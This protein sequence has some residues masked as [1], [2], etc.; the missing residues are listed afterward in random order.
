MNVRTAT[1]LDRDAIHHVH[2]SAFAD[3]ERA[4]VSKLAVNLLQEETSPNTI[5]LVAEL[6]GLVVGH[7]A[8]SPVRIENDENFRGVILAPLGVMPD[9]QNRRIG[10]TLLRSGMQLV[11]RMQA[12]VLFVYGDPKYYGK[13]GFSTDAAGCYVPPY[14]LK[15]PFGWQAIA[16]NKSKSR[17]TSVNVVF[18]TSLSDPALW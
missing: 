1:Q 6:E 18:V 7:V 11:S 3:D 5:S 16:L 8:F 13:F 12:D 14:K 4:I 9:Y 2:W 17:T 15:Y 10:T